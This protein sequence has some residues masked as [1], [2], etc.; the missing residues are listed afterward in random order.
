MMAYIDRRKTIGF[1]N[2]EYFGIE[3]CK[4]DEIIALI[5]TIPT[6]DVE[7]VVRC[8]DCKWAEQV[9]IGQCVNWI[10]KCPW[11]FERYVR[12]GF[13]SYGERRDT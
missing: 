2:N 8:K 10:C 7:E 13:C 1:I 6:A 12:D 3:N 4:V 9:M 5:E 11:M